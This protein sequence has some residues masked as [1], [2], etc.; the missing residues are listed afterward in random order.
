MAT[1]TSSR[2]AYPELVSA[3]LMRETQN[4]KLSS[5]GCH[6]HESLVAGCIDDNHRKGIFIAALLWIIK[7]I[8]FLLLV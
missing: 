2:G 7:I 8:F 4:N 6:F 5:G 3:S 1:E